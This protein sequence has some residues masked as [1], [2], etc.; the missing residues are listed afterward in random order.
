VWALPTARSIVAV[1]FL[2][3]EKGRPELLCTLRTRQAVTRC[4][5]ECDCRL[6]REWA[7]RRFAFFAHRLR[8]SRLDA[9]IA[10]M[11]SRAARSNDRLHDMTDIV[12]KSWRF[13]SWFLWCMAWLGSLT[14]RSA[15]EPKLRHRVRFRRKRSSVGLAHSVRDY[16][17]IGAG[18]GG[19]K[20][21]F[22]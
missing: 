4:F 22:G 21:A 8:C 7:H 5:D 3:S 10:E 20:P 19:R 2:S 14:G 9:L 15:A 11:M 6:W 13:V 17:L 12:C 18:A 1:N 16:R